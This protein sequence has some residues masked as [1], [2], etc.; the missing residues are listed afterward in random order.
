[1]KTPT[2]RELRAVLDDVANALQ[3][4]IGLASH[5]RRNAQSVADDAVTLE[6]AIGRAV[7]ALKRLQPRPGAR[8]RTP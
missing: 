5:V 3:G 7:S 8:R 2:P 6:A 1:M 4:A